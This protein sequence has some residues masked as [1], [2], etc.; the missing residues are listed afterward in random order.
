MIGHEL[1]EFVDHVMN[2]KMIGDEDVRFLRDE[3]L[4][5][6]V[7]T[8]DT[9]DILIALDRAVCRT[10]ALFADYLVAACVDFAVWES[11]VTGH[12]DRET[13]QWLVATLSAGEGP[14]PLARRIAFEVV[15]EAQ[16]CDEALVCFAMSRG[17]ARIGHAKAAPAPVR[18][19]S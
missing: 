15:R 1:R 19:A 11:R 4:G 10:S 2:A 17:G 9:L 18:M 6:V 8:R 7:M 14:S 13:A 5:D 16:S 3:V 12:V